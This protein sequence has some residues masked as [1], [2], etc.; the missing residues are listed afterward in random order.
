M[1]GPGTKVKKRKN[2]AVGDTEAGKKS[3]ATED[4]KFTED[5]ACPWF[6]D[7]PD[8]GFRAVYSFQRYKRPPFEEEDG[9]CGPCI[10]VTTGDASSC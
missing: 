7:H 8:I 9:A 2:L 4:L 5:G 1:W 10:R 3:E 6:I